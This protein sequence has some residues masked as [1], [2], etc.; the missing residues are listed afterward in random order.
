MSP[1]FVFLK[2]IYIYIY[3]RERER[4]TESDNWVESIKIDNEEILSPLISYPH[5][6][7]F[8]IFC[9]WLK[10]GPTLYWK[11]AND[12]MET[13]RRRFPEIRWKGWWK[14]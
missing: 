8:G 3:M 13:N 7:I 6:D 1:I 14:C 12:N 10:K 4:A 5:E 9:R 11:T 2:V